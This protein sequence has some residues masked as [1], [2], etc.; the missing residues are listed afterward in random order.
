MLNGVLKTL[1]AILFKKGRLKKQQYHCRRGTKKSTT[2]HKSSPSSK[3]GRSV[4]GCLF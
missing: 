2:A 4:L 1:A 3:R